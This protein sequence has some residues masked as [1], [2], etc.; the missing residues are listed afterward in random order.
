M[1]MDDIFNQPLPPLNKSASRNSMDESI[2]WF[3]GK[4][5]RDAAEHILDISELILLLFMMYPT[6]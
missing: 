4:I 1:D 3:H 5:T 6:F 2:S